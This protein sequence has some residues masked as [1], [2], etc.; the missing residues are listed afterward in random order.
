[1]VSQKTLGFGTLPLSFLGPDLGL[2]SAGLRTAWVPDTPPQG[3]LACASSLPHAQLPTLH[4][5]PGRTAIDET[6]VPSCVTGQLPQGHW[7]LLKCS[8]IPKQRVR[9]DNF[10][11]WVLRMAFLGQGLSTCWKLLFS[12]SFSEELQRDFQG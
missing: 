6:N 7:H 9:G 10:R 3:W 4:S 12:H 11:L 2:V 1:M 5:T 8:L